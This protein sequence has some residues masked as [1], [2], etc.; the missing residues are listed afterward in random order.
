MN[1]EPL[2]YQNSL[3]SGTLF[4]KHWYGTNVYNCKVRLN[5]EYALIS[6][7]WKWKIHLTKSKPCQ[8][9]LSSIHYATKITKYD[10]S[11]YV[12]IIFEYIEWG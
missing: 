4:Q 1:Y 11:F 6:S 3:F 10:T 8:T 9:F 2:F 7:I 12:R 5:D